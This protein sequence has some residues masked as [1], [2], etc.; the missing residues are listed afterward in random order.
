M[1]A[2]VWDGRPFPEGFSL[3]LV[4][5]PQ[6]PRNWVVVRNKRAGIC[7]SDLH[8]V[9]GGPLPGFAV[10]AP[11]I[12]GHENA[13]VIEKIG[14]GVDSV[15]LGDR[16]AVD[17]M[18]ACFDVRRYPPCDPCLV[19]DYNICENLKYVGFG[20]QGGYGELSPV[21]AIRAV[22]IPEKLSFE[23]AAFLDVLACGVHAVNVG[24]PGLESTIAVVGCGA[25]GLDL[26]QAAKARGVHQIIA[27]ARY[28]FQASLAEKLGADDV[29]CSE[30]GEDPV[31]AVMEL[32]NNKGVDQAY[33]TAGGRSE[34][35]SECLAF[36]RRGGKIVTLGVYRQRKSLDLHRLL[37]YEIDL[38]A[39]ANHGI[40][41]SKREFITSLELLASG[42]ATH[43]PL[44]THAFKIEDWRKAWETVADKKV[45]RSVK[46]E[47][48]YE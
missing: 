24:E 27:V 19:G 44:V 38:V 48:T 22:K 26:I 9:A 40:H 39:S 34:A 18:V 36:T 43:K 32:T 8:N 13:G 17:P 4:E 5:D 35:P 16:V 2:V 30:R 15:G 1:K 47:F 33:E 14:E 45:C 31:R 20:Y 23:E 21:P 28:E 3:E 11:F 10:K 7:G 25:I 42:K 37:L 12:L 41:N 46:V 6:P 29:V